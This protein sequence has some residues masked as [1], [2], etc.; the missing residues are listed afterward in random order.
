[1]ARAQEGEERAEP[2]QRT[3]VSL[4]DHPW[5]TSPS[6]LRRG[7]EREHL[8]TLGPGLPGPSDRRRHANGV[9]ALDVDDLVVELH[10][11][12]ARDHHVDLLGPLVAMGHGGTLVRRNA[13]VGE[14]GVLGLEV[15]VGEPHLLEVAEPE[16]RRGAFTWLS[17]LWVYAP[18]GFASGWPRSSPTPSPTGSTA[19][20]QPRLRIS[21]SLKARPGLD[22]LGRSQ[23]PPSPGRATCARHQQIVHHQQRAIDASLA[24]ASS[25]YSRYSPLVASRN[26][27]SNGPSSAGIVSLGVALDDLYS[28]GHP[29]P[30]QVVGGLGDARG[31]A[32]EGHDAARRSSASAMCS[33]E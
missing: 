2:V 27:R 7:P 17:F 19:P 30:A 23:K 3:P 16:L 4:V 22:R 5:S 12:R 1:M 29:G 6:P 25:R 15:V 10:P 20:R 9:Q 33:V 31:I 18:S 26:S 11:P 24:S 13:L 8:E 32:L 14:A 28:V 21:A